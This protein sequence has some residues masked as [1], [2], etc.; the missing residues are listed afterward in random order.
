MSGWMD[1]QIQPSDLTKFIIPHFSE[2]AEVKTIKY[3]I[4]SFCTDHMLLMNNIS[5]FILLFASQIH[6]T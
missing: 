3:L 5:L 2:P 4:F 6:S 1:E